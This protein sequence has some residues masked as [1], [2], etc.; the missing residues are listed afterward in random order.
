MCLWRSASPSEK[1]LRGAALALLLAGNFR[2][3]PLLRSMEIGRALE[4]D[5]GKKNKLVAI[6]TQAVEA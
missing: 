1:S 5:P 4:R 3:L 6:R 2:P